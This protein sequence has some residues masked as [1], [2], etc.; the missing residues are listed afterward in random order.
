M[1]T[2]AVDVLIIEDSPSDFAL[3]AAVLEASQEIEARIHHADRLTDGLTIAHAADIAVAIIDLSLPDSFGLATFECFHTEYPDVPAII[4][5]GRKD[6]ELAFQAVQKGAQD[7]LFKGEPS[8]T[9]IIRTIRYA[10]ER[11]RLRT[12]LRT[13]SEHIEQLQGLLPICAN[14]KKIRDD[15]GF[16]SRLESYFSAHSEVRFSHSIC[17]ECA[18]ELYPEVVKK[19]PDPN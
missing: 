3:L 1:E 13:A 16:W 15:Q 17:P 9:A 4:M 6:H 10:I 14:C 11:Q 7:Y 19:P 8:E 12:A 2:Q 18:Q 5:T